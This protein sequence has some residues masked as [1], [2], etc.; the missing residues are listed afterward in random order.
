MIETERLLLRRWRAADREPFARMNRDPAVME[1]FP[2]L[3]SRAESDALIDRIEAHFVEHGF[4]LWAAELRGS[5]EFI[6]YVGA[7]GA[8]LFR[9]LYS[10]RRNRVAPRSR[11]L[12]H[13]SCERRSASGCSPWV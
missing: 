7:R 13:G 5:G 12:G 10:M 1:F 9:R 2:S 4:G 11:P 6:G 8:A 3:L